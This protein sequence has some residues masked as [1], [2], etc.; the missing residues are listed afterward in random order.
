M[1]W[2]SRVKLDMEAVVED[3]SDEVLQFEIEG[4]LINSGFVWIV[5]YHRIRSDHI[6][7]CC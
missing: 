5:H 6:R 7:I 2:L 1:E 4:S 3:A